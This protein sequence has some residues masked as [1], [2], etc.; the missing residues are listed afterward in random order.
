MNFWE[1]KEIFKQKNKFY[2]LGKHR[3]NHG[4]KSETNR[5]R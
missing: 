4:D 3:R 5:A 2:T 1:K